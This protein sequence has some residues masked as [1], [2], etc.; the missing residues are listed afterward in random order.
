MKRNLL[1]DGDISVAMLDYR[2][3]EK[4]GDLGATL[5]RNDR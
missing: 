3:F 1:R 4:V 5:P 2:E